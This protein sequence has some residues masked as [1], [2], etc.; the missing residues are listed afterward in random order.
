M[1]LGYVLALLTLPTQSIDTVEVGSSILP[2]PTK[3]PSKYW[4]F[5]ISLCGGEGSG[6]EQ[7]QNIHNIIEGTASLS[8]DRLEAWLKLLGYEL[9]VEAR[10]V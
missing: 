5:V 4:A 7:G 1:I 6:V 3:K 10:K 9:S 2:A 8:F